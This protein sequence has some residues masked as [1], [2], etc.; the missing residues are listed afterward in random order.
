MDPTLNAPMI[1]F[2]ASEKAGHVNG[3][4]VGR[5]GYTFTIFQQYK[6]I[7]G[8]SQPGG[9]TAD[10]VAKNF[11]TVLGQ[12]MTAPGMDITIK[13]PDKPEEKK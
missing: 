5:R 7:A 6:I 13:K 10:D 4:V 2:L 1:A 12:Y 3:Q 8:M 11:D 9:W